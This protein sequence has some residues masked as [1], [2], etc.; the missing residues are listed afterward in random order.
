[1]IPTLLIGDFLFVSKYSMDIARYSMPFSPDLFSG[2]IL[3][4]KPKR[5]DVVVFKLPR[6]TS[7]DTSSAS[8]ACRATASR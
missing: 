7:Q 8:S 5:G 1:M 4:S 2:R 6:D 3:A